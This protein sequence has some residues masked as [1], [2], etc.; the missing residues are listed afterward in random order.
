MN[1]VYG[2]VLE[3]AQ[4][5]RKQAVFNWGNFASSHE[6][7]AVLLE[8]VEELEAELQDIKII[9][10]NMWKYIKNNAGKD[11][12][13]PQACAITSD[14]IKAACKAIQVAAVGLRIQDLL[15]SEGNIGQCQK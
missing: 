13:Y 1:V 6:G 11:A 3:L 7:Y 14:A 10:A 5:E 8:E 2:D 15:E 12:I 4:K 9:Q